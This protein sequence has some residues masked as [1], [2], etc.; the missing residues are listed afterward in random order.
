MCLFEKYSLQPSRVREGVCVCVAVIGAGVAG[1]RKC[2]P[3]SQSLC[4][5]APIHWQ[6]FLGVSAV[7][8]N[9]KKTVLPIGSFSFVFKHLFVIYLH[10]FIYYP[11]NIYPQ[12]LEVS[13]FITSPTKL[14]PSKYSTFFSC[15][16]SFLSYSLI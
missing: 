9:R 15:D 3:P 1:Q 6:P 11:R 4:S 8:M 2:C 13:D 5:A 16:L 10:Q 14:C 12:I 7:C